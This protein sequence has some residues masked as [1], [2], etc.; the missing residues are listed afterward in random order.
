MA[1]SQWHPGKNETYFFEVNFPS[2]ILGKAWV[3]ETDWNVASRSVGGYFFSKHG[4]WKL[5]SRKYFQSLYE[6]SIDK[7]WNS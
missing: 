7:N 4:L 5:E 3:E 2:L 1:T 6:P